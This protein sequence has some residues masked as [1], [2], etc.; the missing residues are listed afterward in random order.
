MI[1]A[2]ILAALTFVPVQID[3]SL[4]RPVMI[5]VAEAAEVP[6]EPAPEP[7]PVDV[8]DLISKYAAEYGVKERSMVKT[9]QCENPELDP[10][11]QSRARYTADHPEWGVRAGDRELSW[12]IVQVH[13]PSWPEISLEQAQDADFSVRFMA[14]MFA[15]GKANHWSCWKSLKAAGV[16]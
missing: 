4:A 9:I 16:I 2:A 12:G 11:L 10:K 8:Y 1:T 7:E 6:S 5:Y 15:D 3:F 14:Q 13:L